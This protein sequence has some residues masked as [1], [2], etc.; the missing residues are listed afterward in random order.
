MVRSARQKV[1]KE[2]EEGAVMTSPGLD[3]SNEIFFWDTEIKW[4][5]DAEGGLGF[6][7]ENEA[8]ARSK[9]GRTCQKSK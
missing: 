8:T 1:A 3:P 7:L 9:P 4:G 6:R 2:R 5:L